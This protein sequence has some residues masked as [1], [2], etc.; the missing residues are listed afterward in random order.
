[1]FV[2]EKIP[3]VRSVHP[4]QRSVQS[5]NVEQSG[6][7]VVPL[8]S[9]DPS[10]SIDIP[11]GSAEPASDGNLTVHDEPGDGSN[12]GTNN[13][14]TSDDA[15][16]ERYKDEAGVSLMLSTGSISNLAS[17]SGAFGIKSTT[18]VLHSNEILLP[19][20]FKSEGII[21]QL[22]SGYIAILSGV[23][24]LPHQMDAASKETSFE[25]G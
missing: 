18:A 10:V 2:Y 25:V 14:C 19:S 12:G 11:T 20:Q 8:N 5:G 22:R 23:H 4:R 17:K 15:A 13:L 1:M 24:H 6:L 3:S 9:T 16:T 21:T 7:I